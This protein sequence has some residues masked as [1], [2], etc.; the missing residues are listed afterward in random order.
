MAITVRGGTIVTAGAVEAFADVH[1]RPLGRHARKRGAAIA[2][3]RPINPTSEETMWIP[4][5]VCCYMGVVGV[6]CVDVCGGARSGGGND[7]IE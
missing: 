2:V 7:A 5:P 3:C 1:K 4:S 6:C